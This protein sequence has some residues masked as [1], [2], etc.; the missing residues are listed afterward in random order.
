MS[1]S[2]QINNEIYETHGHDWWSEDAKFDFSG[3]RYCVNPV[4]YNYFKSKLGQLSLSGKTVLDLGCGGGFLA[5]EFAKDGFKVTGIDPSER[6]IE[7][8]RQ[9]AADDDL[10]IDYRIGQGEALPF[11]DDSF[12]II[13][14]CDVLEHVDDPHKVICEV[15]RTLK[16]GGIFFYD[17]IN[18]T[19]WSKVALIKIW[20][21]WPITRI[22]QPHVHVWEKFITPAEL[23]IMLRSCHLANRGRKGISP[24][25]KNPF[26]MLWT[27]RAIRNGK[28]RNEQLADNIGLCETDNLKISYMGYAIKDSDPN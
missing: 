20:Q 25:K 15:A 9:H 16:M 17:T 28:I 22:S 19:W 2:K 4:R 6:S 12:D 21:D 7:A 13:A 10:S 1:R 14:C 11:P 26:S 18:R 23:D 8:A 5:E 24:R 3:L 27:I